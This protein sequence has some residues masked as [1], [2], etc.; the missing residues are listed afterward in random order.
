MTLARLHPAH[1]QTVNDIFDDFLTGFPFTPAFEMG[2]RLKEFNPRI[3]VYEDEKNVYI[4]ADIPG[5][6]KED[7]KLEIKEDNLTICGERKKEEVENKNYYRSERFFGSFCRS[8]SLPDT[9]DK[10]R[11]D[12]KFENGTLQVSIPKV[13]NKEPEVQSIAIK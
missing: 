1:L 11:V 3:D 7:I 9:L 4:E 13:E 2:K 10:A 6:K 5:V 12:A 8:F